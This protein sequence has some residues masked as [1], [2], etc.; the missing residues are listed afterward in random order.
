MAVERWLKTK[1]RSTFPDGRAQ[2]HAL[3][4]TKP[5]AS[6]AA[7]RQSQSRRVKAVLGS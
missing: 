6:N 7:R 1:S 5:V 4:S 2:V 3:G